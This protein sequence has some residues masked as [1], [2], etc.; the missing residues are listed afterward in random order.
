VG[1]RDPATVPRARALLC[2]CPAPP[3]GASGRESRCPRCPAPRSAALRS[4][5][6]SAGPGQT[7]L[8]QKKQ[9]RLISF[10]FPPHVVSCGARPAFR[11]TQHFAGER[12]VPSLA[13]AAG[14][15]PPTAEAAA[16]AAAMSA[17]IKLLPPCSL[18]KLTTRSLQAAGLRHRALQPS[19]PGGRHP[20]C[21]S[22]H[23]AGPQGA[24][25]SRSHSSQTT[26]LCKPLSLV[27]IATG[28]SLQHLLP[29][30]CTVVAS[31]V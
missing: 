16:G 23:V 8:A 5:K 1:W 15:Q 18:G 31:P 26:Q 7:L 11:Y 29:G 12:L 30:T 17:E 14:A 4:C 24:T 13:G 9:Q 20:R 6:G 19:L 22:C 25:S 2:C 3:L 27:F 10:P 21:A 28:K